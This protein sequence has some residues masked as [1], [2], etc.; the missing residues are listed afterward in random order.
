MQSTATPDPVLIQFFSKISF[1]IRKN[2]KYRAGYAILSILTSAHYQKWLESLFQTPTPFL[3]QNFWIRVRVRL[4]F[5]FEH[6][7]PVPTPLQSSIQPW[8]THVFFPRNDHADSCYSRIR[9]VTPGPVFH[10]FLTPCPDP[11]PKEKRRIPPESTVDKPDPVPP[12]PSRPLVLY[13]MGSQSA[14]YGAPGLRERNLGAPRAIG[15]LIKILT[16]LILQ[17]S[18]EAITALIKFIL[19]LRK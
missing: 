6:P 11:D 15:L 10:R 8:F 17:L 9:N 12:L 2:C 1:Q 5:K 4:F 16:W 7:T 19:G 3:F 18:K 13:L 14:P